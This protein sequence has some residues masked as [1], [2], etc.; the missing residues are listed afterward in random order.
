M[1]AAANDMYAHND[2]LT[3]SNKLTKIAGAHGLKF[4]ATLAAAAEAAELPEQRG[5]VPGLRRSGLD[6]GQH[7]QRGRRH[8]DGPASRRSTA[9]GSAP[10]ERRVP[11]VELRRVRAGFLEAPSEPHARVRRPRRLLDEQPGAQRA[12]RATSIRRATTRTRAQFLDPGTF[13]VLNGYCYVSTAAPTPACCRTAARSR[14]RASTSRGTSTARATTCSAAATGCSTT[15]TWATSSTTTPCALPPTAYQISADVFDSADPDGSGVGLTYDTLDNIRARRPHRRG[16]RRLA[17]AGFVHVPEDAQLQRLVRAPHPV[18]PGASRRPTSARAAATW[19]AASTAT[20]I[21]EG[22]LLHGHGRQRRPAQPGAPR[23]A[24][25]QR[26]QP[27]PALPRVPGPHYYDFEG[28]SNYNSLQVTLSRQTGTP[29]AVLRHLHPRPH[30]GHA[31][32]RVPQPRSVQPDAHLRHPP[33]RPHPRLQPLVE[34]VPAGRASRRAATRSP[35]A[36]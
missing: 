31:R 26:R 18:Q 19:S 32:R 16:R 27:V 28:E 1:W 14:C 22:A 11:H 6:A 15:A 35:R 21:A 10:P 33:G 30:Q 12:R 7:R 23:R 13:R 36:C 24:R 4:G 9:P 34:R 20:P 29:P 3:F 25:R 2:E 5:D 17:D 8:A